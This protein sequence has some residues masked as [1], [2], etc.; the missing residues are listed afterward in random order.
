MAL[1]WV[2]FLEPHARKVYAEDA[3]KEDLGMWQL[4][5]KILGKS[6][7][8]YDSIRSIYRHKWPGLHNSE[9]VQN[10]ISLLADYSWATTETIKNGPGQSIVIR[11]NPE[12]CSLHGQKQ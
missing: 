2:E 12:V 8:D 3:S 6:V 10:A 1:K 7:N 9:E 11:I 4:S 5:R